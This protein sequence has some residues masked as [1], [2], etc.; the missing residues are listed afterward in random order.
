[1]KALIILVLTLTQA[2][3]A[4]SFKSGG[5]GNGGHPYEMEFKRAGK[6]IVKILKDP[7]ISKTEELKRINLYLLELNLETLKVEVKNKRKGLKDKF[8]KRKCALNFPGDKLIQI[9][10]KCWAKISSKSH[11]KLPFVLHELL[12]LSG[13]E[14]DHYN[15]SS[16]LGGSIDSFIQSLVQV[17]DLESEAGKAALSKNS[18]IKEIVKVSQESISYYFD[19]EK[20]FGLR[21]YQYKTLDILCQNMGYRFS[22]DAKSEISNYLIHTIMSENGSIYLSKTA[23]VDKYI[24][25][26]TCAR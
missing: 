19:F 11:M 16:R 20:K 24:S 22:V 23:N 8:G 18:A 10:E 21:K 3:F 14:V 1:M 4:Q 7:Y 15:I 13:E 2:S 9:D 17:V 12:G 5:M 25:E 26:V 6:Q